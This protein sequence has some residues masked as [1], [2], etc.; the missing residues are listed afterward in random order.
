MDKLFKVL[1]MGAGTVKGLSVCEAL[2]MKEMEDVCLDNLYLD[3]YSLASR[4][5]DIF[6][7]IKSDVIMALMFCH[8]VAKVIRNCPRNSDIITVCKLLLLIESK[9][10]DRSQYTGFHIINDTELHELDSSVKENIPSPN[11][12]GSALFLSCYLACISKGTLTCV[13]CCSVCS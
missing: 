7:Q 13:P 4:T 10:L 1:I 11:G 6:I 12:K 5:F 8:F 9:N 2:H 3:T